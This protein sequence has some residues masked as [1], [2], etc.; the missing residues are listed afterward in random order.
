M[1][2]GNRRGWQALSILLYGQT[3]RLQQEDRLK[4][5]IS[6]EILINWLLQY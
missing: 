1:S 5:E 3:Y 2:A 6:Q 4:I